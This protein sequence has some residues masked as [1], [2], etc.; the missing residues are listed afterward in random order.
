MSN[1]V[2]KS[3]IRRHAT[4]EAMAEKFMVPDID[5]PT[6]AI[7]VETTYG[8]QVIPGWLLGS[9]G[10]TKI[11]AEDLLPYLDVRSV[12]DIDEWE[13]RDQVYLACM[14]APGYID[15]TDWSAHKTWEEAADSL[16]D[17]Y[18]SDEEHFAGDVAETAARL[19]E[20]GIGEDSE[21]LQEVILSTFESM[22]ADAA[23][24]E[25]DNDLVE[26]A[27]E[28]R[29]QRASDVLNGSLE[30]QVRALLSHMA[31]T[32]EA[33]Q[34]ALYQQLGITQASRAGEKASG[35]PRFG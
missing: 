26:Q 7:V 3:D 9:Q 15:R 13:V 31:S 18:A 10:L 19:A 8:T 22:A 28:D 20:A 17:L 16:I 12:D 14:T 33:A 24:Q 35:R 23:N 1:P 29:M 34:A 11:E 2:S 21:K 25:T 32:P 30:E 6:S 5:G 4:L 27:L